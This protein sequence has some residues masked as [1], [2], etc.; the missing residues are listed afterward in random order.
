MRTYAI[1]NCGEVVLIKIAEVI[2]LHPFI[3]HECKLIERI[4]VGCSPA[5]EDILLDAFALGKQ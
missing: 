5:K 2:A 1:I 4:E 3:K